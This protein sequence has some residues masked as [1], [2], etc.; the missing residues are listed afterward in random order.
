MVTAGGRD[1]GVS[2]AGP[3]RSHPRSS[4]SPASLVEVEALTP[5][6]TPCPGALWSRPPRSGRAPSRWAPHTLWPHVPIR[7]ADPG[8]SAWREGQLGTEVRGCSGEVPL[9]RAANVG[10]HSGAQGAF[11]GESGCRGEGRAAAQQAGLPGLQGGSS[12]AGL[13]HHVFIRSLVHLSVPHCVCPPPIRLS[14]RR[15]GSLRPGTQRPCSGHGPLPSRPESHLARRPP[16]G[17]LRGAPGRTTTAL[18][19][20]PGFSG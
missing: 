19:R 6:H 18:H 12:E 16:D 7:S 5:G 3:S 8:F 10:L 20:T 15:W 2:L 11:S 9:P 4:G 17:D 1:S 14:V 13:G